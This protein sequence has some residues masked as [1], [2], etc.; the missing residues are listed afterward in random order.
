MEDNKL[1]Q[2]ER[3][4]KFVNDPRFQK[5]A[6]NRK[7]VKIEKRFQSMFNDDKFKTNYTVDKYGKRIKKTST[8][9]LKRFY[10]LESEGSSDEDKSDAEEK[11]EKSE[12]E[13][14]RK[15]EIAISNE[16]EVKDDDPECEE[17]LKSKL[18]NPVID[19]ARGEARLFSDSS[20]EEEFETDDEAVEEEVVDHNWGEVDN[21][22]ET[23]EDATRRIAIC[24]MDWDRIR[25][26]DIMVLC[27]S[28]VPRGG[29]I[30]SVKIYPSEF[31]K[32]RLAEEEQFGPQEL[33]K[34]KKEES[35]SEE[36]KAYVDDEDDVDMEN[37]RKY[38]LKRLKYFYG[39]IECDSVETADN[40]YKECDGIEYESTANKVD[41]R[42]IPDDM[43]FEDEEVKDVCTDLPNLD[44]YQP[45]TYTTTALQQAKVE[46]TWDEGSLERKEFGSKIASGKLDDVSEQEMKKFI[47]FSSEEE[48]EEEEEEKEK[49][50][51]SKY[52]S[53]LDE[54]NQEEERQNKEKFEREY[55]WGI[56]LEE[57]I[58]S[59]KKDKSK[60]T[61]IEQILDKRMEKK[62]LKKEKKKEQQPQVEEEDDIPDGIDM[63]DEYFAEEFA[64]GDFEE[65]KKTKKDKKRKHTEDDTNESKELSLLIDDDE[66]DGRNHFSLSKI[67]KAENKSGKKSRKN[68]R[69]PKD[70][71]DIDDF[72]INLDDNRFNALYTSQLFNIDPSDSKYKKTKAMEKIIHKKIQRNIKE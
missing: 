9:E 58:S 61:P 24:N 25:A 54:I 43:D 10:E 29:S 18:R 26:S 44:K 7:K 34:E 13:E 21:D 5:F 53:L 32:Q 19:Y 37:L 42:F 2:D 51:R 12:I 16:A 47:A 41:L 14:Q 63:N 69:K 20:S 68:K 50:V 55:T 48:D 60:M 28:F 67:Q 49:D 33:K 52:A 23:T 38:Q 31:G 57:C 17:D 62:L 56:G 22:A 3:F 59:K 39:V 46:L 6:P 65:K 8:E 1:N 36:E 72:E 15:E 71:Q 70:A 40:I 11:S 35:D 27:N 45:R 66:E 64:N 4:S 30:L